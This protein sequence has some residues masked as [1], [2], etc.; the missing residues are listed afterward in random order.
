MTKLGQA[1]QEY[2]AV[3]RALGFKL[4]TEG[5]LLQKFV[6][7]AQREGATT[8]TKDLA[9]R[10]AMQPQNC[11]PSTWAKRLRMVRQFARFCLGTDPRTEIP[12]PDLLPHRSR[13]RTPHFYS[14]KEIARLL[15]AAALLPS[16][17]GLRAQSYATLLGLLVV[18]GM[19]VSEPLALDRKDVDLTQGILT[20]RQ[21]KFG[22][23]RLVPLHSTTRDALIRY[24]RFRNRCC[25]HPLD[26]T[27]FLGEQGRR[28]K[29]SGVHWTFVQLSRKIGLRKP[30]DSFG[31]R[32][33]D[34]RHHF[35]ITTLRDW[36]RSGIDITPRMLT[37]STFLGHADVKHT[38]WYLS[39][40]PELLNLASQRLERMKGENS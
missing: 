27:F 1:L 11:Q 16:P 19:R 18:T 30:T 35:A 7:F 6:H 25:P 23:S 17:C 3:R 40:T 12:Q 4:R 37:L 9:L 21:A 2:L 34:L 10:W 13:R 20:V 32:I 8:I 39:A 33:H 15:K 22:K 29:Q 38:Y 24:A 26:S 31:P 36:Y 14:N 28:L 5:N